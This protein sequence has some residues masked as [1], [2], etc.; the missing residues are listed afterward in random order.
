MVLW[1]EEMGNPREPALSQSTSILYSGT[2][3]MPLGL[4]ATS[5]WS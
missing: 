2:S 3:S 5:L 4:T 1:M